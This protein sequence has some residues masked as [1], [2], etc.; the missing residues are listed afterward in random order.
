VILS[1]GEELK[2]PISQLKGAQTKADPTA[3]TFAQ[4]ERKAIIDALK[5]AT[6]QIRFRA[7]WRCR[8][9]G[10]EAYNPAKQKE[11]IGYR[12]EERLRVD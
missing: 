8:V 5:D 6:G 1:Q 3:T 10:P 2:V 11:A 4:A 12:E 9:V 7:W